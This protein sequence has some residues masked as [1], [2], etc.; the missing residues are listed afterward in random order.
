MKSSVFSVRIR[1]ELAC[2]T[3]PEFSVERVSSLVMTPSAARG[4]LES[5][6]WKPAI[7]WQIQR[8]KILS[9][10]KFIQFRRNEVNSKVSVD[11]A[12]SAMKN[13]TAFELV[14]DEDRTQRN[15]IALRDVDYAV[16]AYMAMTRR[17]GP[18]DNLRKFEEMFERRL[19][20]GQYVTP[21][22]LGCREFP[23][24][25]EPYDGS[26]A[27]IEEDH[28]FG[29]LLLDIRFG[30]TNQASFFHA[31]M[32]GGVIDVPLSPAGPEWGV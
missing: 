31:R 13:A 9:P 32:K 10:P 28:D 5:I 14:A 19:E 22:V 23:A 25:V 2:F 17:W 27:P 20:R 4:I 30:K 26:P 6:L 3:A 12:R 18:G 24:I 7:F 29:Q 21:P 11:S 15:T 8:I 1:G 16:D